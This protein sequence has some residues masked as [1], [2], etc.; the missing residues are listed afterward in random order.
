VKAARDPEHDAGVSQCRRARPRAATTAQAQPRRLS[1]AKQANH[2]ARASA[3]GP[4]FFFPAA[5]KDQSHTLLH[6]PTTF[7]CPGQDDPAG[8]CALKAAQGHVHTED[9][10]GY[11]RAKPT[12]C[13]SGAARRA[14]LPVMTRT[15]GRPI[16]LASLRE[17]TRA[18]AD[19]SIVGPERDWA[20]SGGKSNKL[21]CV[22]LLLVVLDMCVCAV[23][24][25]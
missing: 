25:V 11:H 19:C 5:A 21:L 14:S 2:A 16:Q 18:P 6:P 10:A 23:C 15:R 13:G 8:A 4:L 9:R 22:R 7:L 17:E 1:P 12:T 3:W 24:C 20:K